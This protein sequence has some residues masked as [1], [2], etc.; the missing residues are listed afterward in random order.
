MIMGDYD[1]FEVGLPF[2]PAPWLLAVDAMVSDV[3]ECGAASHHEKLLLQ[4]FDHQTSW[5]WLALLRS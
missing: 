3:E 5:S 4:N 2:P 1:C